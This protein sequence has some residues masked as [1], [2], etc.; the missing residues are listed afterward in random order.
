MNG[1]LQ[2]I[3]SGT[4]IDPTGIILTNAHVGD[5][6]QPGLALQYGP[7]EEG[8]TSPDKLVVAMF[9]GEDKPA[10]ETYTA[11]VLAIDGYLDAAVLKIDHTVGGGDPG[12]LHLPAIDLGDSDGLKEHQPLDIIGYPGVGGGFEGSNNTSAGIVSGFTSDPRIK[13]T[14]RAWIKTDADIN[15][16]NS[17][18][19]AADRGGRIV[20][21]P[22]ASAKSGKLGQVRPINLIKPLIETAMQGQAWQSPYF[23]AETGAEK[24]TFKGWAASQ[25]D[26]SCQFQ[27]AEKGYSAGTTQLLA[28]YDIA[29]M[30]RNEDWAYEWDYVKD[31]DSEAQVLDAGQ[32]QWKDAF[33]QSATCFAIPVGSRSALPAGD[34]Y[35]FLDYGPSRKS[36][37]GVKVSVLTSNT[38]AQSGSSTQPVQPTPTGPPPAGTGSEVAC[39]SWD[40]LSYQA[41]ANG[42]G[43]AGGSGFAV[44]AGLD[45]GGNEVVESG[46][47]TL[48]ELVG[49][50]R[51][52][53]SLE[54]AEGAAAQD[55]QSFQQRQEDEYA[56]NQGLGPYRSWS[57]RIARWLVVSHASAY[58]AYRGTLWLPQVLGFNIG[59]A[60]PGIVNNVQ[61]HY[62]QNPERKPCLI[63]PNDGQLAAWHAVYIPEVTNQPVEYSSPT[64]P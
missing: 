20:G 39:V 4:I 16:G 37:D 17:G 62:E 22:S 63:G 12:S 61:P 34:Y 50:G 45:G 33:Q 31:K 49:D 8:V 1:E 47:V 43:E 21:I 18:G 29:G 25:P 11:R 51:G 40:P 44:P 27:S 59:E 15:G 19:L 5:P 46:P 13:S 52:Y 48:S 60:S 10:K 24:F 2:Y 3:G 23:V 26:Q 30:E 6:L 64:Q 58:Y 35:L 7:A 42:F 38:S 36:V 55:L 56:Q 14:N 41:A 32:T 57:Y 54:E 53:T 9:Q 28:I